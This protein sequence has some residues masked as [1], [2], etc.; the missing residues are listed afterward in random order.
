MHVR[1]VRRH[2]SLALSV[3]LSVSLANVEH[4]WIGQ[5]TGSSN[6]QQSHDSSGN[7]SRI[8]YANCIVCGVQCGKLRRE[9]GRKS[10]FN[11]ISRFRFVVCTSHNAYRRSISKRISHWMESMC[12]P[13][14]APSSPPPPPPLCRRWM[15]LARQPPF[16]RR[17]YRCWMH[18]WR[19]QP[20]QLHCQSISPQ[21]HG[22]QSSPCEHPSISCM[23]L[24]PYTCSAV[25]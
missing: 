21:P 12:Q 16:S 14:L 6:C 8:E 23:K 22:S 11:W 20:P 1:F 17:L 2:P 10:T 3:H 18:L 4:I 24:R 9:K 19:P 13:S 5:W 7:I 15:S 25:H